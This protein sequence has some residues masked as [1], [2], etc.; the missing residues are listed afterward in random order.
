MNKKKVIQTISQ[1]VCHHFPNLHV[2]ES[3]G[4]MLRW[5]GGCENGSLHETMLVQLGSCNETEVAL[6]VSFIVH[7]FKECP[8]PPGVF[9]G[10]LNLVELLY[11]E[12]NLN[13]I[14]SRLGGLNWLYFHSSDLQKELEELF[15]AVA[16]TLK[17][18][19]AVLAS[20]LEADPFR[21]SAYE[22]ALSVKQSPP[23][24]ECVL[25]TVSEFG[26]PEIFRDILYTASK[27]AHQIDRWLRGAKKWS[28]V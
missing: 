20:E 25:A 6:N 11:G 27:A 22:Y 28:E 15:A 9:G 7:Y 12:N 8:M 26:Q 13:E 18:N 2:F 24:F 16:A 17:K 10:S 5:S 1:V 14:Q 19:I 21:K 3:N 4:R 23:A